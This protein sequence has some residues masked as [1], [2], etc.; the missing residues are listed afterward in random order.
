MYV[1][2]R[3]PRLRGTA[4]RV[5]RSSLRRVAGVAFVAVVLGLLSGCLQ[6]ETVVNVNADGSG[7]VE[8][9]F[10]MQR[11]LV[12]MLAEMS[13]AS[14]FSLLD[15]EELERAAGDYGEGVSFERAQKVETEWGSGYRAVYQF[16]DINELRVNQNPSDDIPSEG[17]EMNDG[18]PTATEY[19]HFSF[20]SGELSSLE[21]LMP[22]YADPDPAGRADGSDPAGRADGS[23][24]DGAGDPAATD[25]ASRLSQSDLEGLANLYRDMRIRVD[26]VI[27]GSIVE[28]DASHHRE[29]TITL[30]D[31]DFNRVLDRPEVMEDLARRDPTSLSEVES[32]V[33][34][35]PGIEAELKERVRVQFRP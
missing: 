29:N 2:N 27:N 26:V 12:S 1:V 20:T 18:G 8:E 15:R 30:I 25:G 3:N 9:T 4:R 21:I 10:L 17:A 13:E 11:Q 7:T 33:N 22:S 35:L 32:V 34:R 5:R 14:A 24:P 23:D 6:S 16:T 28:T 19:I 31:M